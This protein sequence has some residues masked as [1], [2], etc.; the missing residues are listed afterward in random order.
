VI[1]AATFVT[2][3]HRQPSGNTYAI[4]QEI[5]PDTPLVPSLGPT[6]TVSLNALA[7]Q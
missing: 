4:A 5:A 1:N 7:L 6:L 3:V 2:T